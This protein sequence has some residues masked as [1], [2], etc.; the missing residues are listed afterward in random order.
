MIIKKYIILISIILINISFISAEPITLEQSDFYIQSGKTIEVGTGASY[1]YAKY[2]YASDPTVE[3]EN[4][5]AVIPVFLRFKPFQNIEISLKSTYR[6]L[7]ETE[8]NILKKNTGYV[9]GSGKLGLF[10][11]CALKLQAEIPGANPDD[12]AVEGLNIGAR[13]LI[14]IKS[15]PLIIHLNGGY[16]Y[17]FAYTVNSMQV[18]PGNYIFGG[19]GVE[20]EMG[21]VN[22]LVEVT[23]MSVGKSVA[24]GV[25][26]VNEPLLL[27]ILAGFSWKID[28][29]KIKAGFAYSL[30]TYNI[31]NWKIVS[32]VSILL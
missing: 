25:E 6:L 1:G 10:E 2:F 11:G 14:S 15:N 21:G 3:Y 13:V 29:I 24:G 31:Y 28:S 27:D 8:F 7:K 19:A 30:D 12:A 9:E 20:Y 17:S 18:D 4:K 22:P 26:D 32:G 23:V 16:T 5:D